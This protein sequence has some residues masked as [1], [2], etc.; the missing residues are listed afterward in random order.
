MF[1]IPSAKSTL[2]L[3]VGCHWLC[4]CVMF[5]GSRKSTGSASGTRKL[6]I[7]RALER[8]CGPHQLINENLHGTSPVSSTSLPPSLPLTRNRKAG[9]PGRPFL[10]SWSSD[11]CRA[12]HSCPSQGLN[13]Q[14]RRAGVPIVKT[15]YRRCPCEISHALCTLQLRLHSLNSLLPSTSSRVVRYSFRPDAGVTKFASNPFGSLQTLA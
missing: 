8:K 7:D 2:R 10:N 14:R 13:A 5:G 15:I 11:F 3:R 4:Q 9:T 12:C 1:Q 6:S